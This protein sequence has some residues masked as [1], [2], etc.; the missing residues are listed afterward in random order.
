MLW[1]IL[2]LQVLKTSDNYNDFFFLGKPNI[3][4]KQTN[5]KFEVK[6]IYFYLSTI[7]NWKDKDITI[8][9]NFKSPNFKSHVV[10]LIDVCKIVL[11]NI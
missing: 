11:I 9:P 5:E 4:Q 6:A 3:S 8:N 1:L 2:F 7:L 10:S